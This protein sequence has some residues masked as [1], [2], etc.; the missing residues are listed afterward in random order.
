MVVRAWIMRKRDTL[1]AGFL[2]YILIGQD[3]V[4]KT[5]SLPKSYYL[6]LAEDLATRE[7]RAVNE[8]QRDMGKVMFHRFGKWRLN[9]TD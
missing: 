4:S 7:P 6:L 1:V 9:G 8:E 3:K 2:I 5:C